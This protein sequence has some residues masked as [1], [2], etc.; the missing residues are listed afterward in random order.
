MRAMAVPTAL[1]T[2]DRTSRKTT[3]GDIV[4]GGGTF[5][6]VC[7]CLAVCTRQKPT[8]SKLRFSG[9]GKRGAIWNDSNNTSFKAQGPFD[10]IVSM[11]VTKP[12]SLAGKKNN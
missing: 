5:V 4:A 7:V 11:T 12:I 2:R 3:D 8:I 9:F 1:S 6:S 10:R